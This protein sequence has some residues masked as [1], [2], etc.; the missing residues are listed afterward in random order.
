[1]FK[2][3]CKIRS[4]SKLANNLIACLSNWHYRLHGPCLCPGCIENPRSSVI[5]L[6]RRESTSSTHMSSC[7]SS[8]QHPEHHALPGPNAVLLIEEGVTDPLGVLQRPG[9]TVPPTTPNQRRQA[10]R[11]SMLELSGSV[12][13]KES[14]NSL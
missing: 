1:M 8:P 7:D 6:F 4:I 3:V 14:H 5:G 9:A 2:I 12:S 13:Q 10:R 11:G